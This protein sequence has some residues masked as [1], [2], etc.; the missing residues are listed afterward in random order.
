MSATELQQ[1]RGDLHLAIWTALSASAANS[2]A[3]R[4]IST[5]S[6]FGSNPANEEKTQGT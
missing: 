1:L 6:L 3:G 2:R 5:Q 4:A